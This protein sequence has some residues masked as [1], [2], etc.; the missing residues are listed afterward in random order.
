MDPTWTQS[1]QGR[2]DLEPKKSGQEDNGLGKPGPRTADRPQLILIGPNP[3]LKSI[4][5]D[6]YR[7]RPVS[8]ARIEPRLESR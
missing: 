5:L 8:K 7:M 1:G 6:I 4:L 2:S 3:T